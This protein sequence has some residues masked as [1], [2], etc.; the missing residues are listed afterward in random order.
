MSFLRRWLP[1]LLAVL[2]P[3]GAQAQGARGIVTGK[4]VE[5]ESRLPIAAAQVTV[6]GTTITTTTRPDGSYRIPNA[7]AGSIEL[8]VLRIG[9]SDTRRTV[10]VVAGQVV[11][12]DIP[13]QKVAVNLTPVVT[14]ATGTQDRSVVPNQIPT[15]DVTKLVDEAPIQNVADVLVSKVAGVSLQGGSSVGAGQRIR[16]RGTASLS[17][18]N[19]PIVIID[20]VRANSDNQQAFG[21][22]GSPTSRLNDI[23]PDDIE[24][25]EVLRGPAASATYGTD[26]ATGVIVITTKRGRAGAPR[27]NFYTE[28]GLVQDRNEYPTAYTMWGRN[29]AGTASQDCFNITIAAG[30]CRPDSLTT[31]NLW[32]DPRASPLKDGYRFVYGANV[33]GGTEAS[34]YFVSAETE[35]TSGTLTIPQFDQARLRRQGV[36]IDEKWL[37]PND[38]T[39]SGARVNLD[40]R[41][42][43]DVQL[44]IRTFFSTTFFRNPQDGNN[45]NGLG[46]HAYGG[47]G[48]FNRT[49]AAGDSLGGYR[50][51]TPGDMFQQTTEQ[52]AHRFVGSINPQWT[53]T[54]WL[55][56][57]AALGIDFASATETNRCLRDQCPNFGQ[58]RLGFVNISRTRDFRYTAE[59]TATATFRLASWLNSRTTGGFQFVN[60]TGDNLNASGNQL[61]PGG[62]TITQASVYSANEGTFIAR[63]AGLFVEQNLTFRN[64]FTLRGS[65]RGDNNSAFGQNFGTAYYPSVG[66]TWSLQEEKWF[67]FKSTVNQ[68]RLRTSWG[69][70]GLRPGTTAA[71]PFF[72]SNVFRAA[73]ADAPG[74]IFQQLGDISLRPETLTEWEGGLDVNLFRDRITLEVNRYDRR[75]EDAIVNRVVAP[76]FG[77][78]TATQATNLGSVRNWGWEARLFTQVV[79]T[80]PF[81]LDVTFNFS[82]NDNRLRTLG[83]DATGNPIPPIIGNLI[84]QVPGF[85]LNGYW[86]RRYTYDDANGDG[87]I[88]P[89]EL[90]P[91]TTIGFLGYSIPRNELSTILGGEFF[92]R[93]VRVQALFD[94]RGGHFIDNGT[95]RFRCDTRNNARERVDPTASLERQ[96]RCAALFLP[97][98]TRTQFGYLEPGDYLRFRELAVT[99]RVP[100]DWARKVVRS[101]SLTVTASGRNLATWTKFTGVDPE[102]TG[103]L[104][105][106]ADEFQVTPPL[107]FFTLRFNIGY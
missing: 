36:T 40:I 70:A 59:A 89:A 99:W 51:F 42:P 82:R 86:Q 41:L 31:F 106:V 103:P 6:V 71:L 61:P 69:R 23:N 37:N 44:P 90:R 52:V 67:P 75:S 46:S 76:S 27:F 66:A 80:K 1:A 93:R 65:L 33:S 107:S 102:T 74:L 21:T 12:L 45:T 17:L 64:N 56:A 15:L 18:G 84:R 87:L 43:A 38:Y 13:M 49:T 32:R 101:R 7:P 47:P 55:V 20:G 10:R 54:S 5:S 104:G 97:A 34:Q 95:E 4:V 92:G 73:G 68:F 105:N 8:R 77:T 100:E 62:L 25:L 11:S 19:A 63:T 72:A 57:R 88:A 39:R 50:L 91:D 24:T 94:Y 60:N 78:G 85:P 81:G 22:G 79:D 53:P 9:F 48:T 28:Q 29:A 83:T 96:A 3:L 98:A 2:V 58:N 30:T 14:T 26:A 35:G 16:I